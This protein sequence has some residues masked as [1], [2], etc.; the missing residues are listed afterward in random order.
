MSFVGTAIA[1]GAVVTAGVGVAKAIDG[2]VQARKAKKE[3][4]NAQKE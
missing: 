3:A 4:E 2:G 1:I